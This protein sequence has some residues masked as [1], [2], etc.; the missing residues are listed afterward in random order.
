MASPTGILGFRDE[1]G[2]WKI[3]RTWKT[4]RSV[5]KAGAN[6]VI[7]QNATRKGEIRNDVET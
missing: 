6:G 4:T 2:S 1:K 3:I 7:I 5:E